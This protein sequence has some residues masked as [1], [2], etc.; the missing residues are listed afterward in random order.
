M[1]MTFVVKNKKKLTSKPKSKYNKFII[2]NE[3]ILYQT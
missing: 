2:K 3:Q 1:Y